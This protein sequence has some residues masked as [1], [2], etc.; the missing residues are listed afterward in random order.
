[1]AEITSD[2][3]TEAAPYLCQ[4]VE[5]ILWSFEMHKRLFETNRQNDPLKSP[6]FGQFF[7]RLNELLIDHWFLCVA[8]L[9]DRAYTSQW[10]L[11]LE[12][13]AELPHLDANTAKKMKEL[14]QRMEGF[15]DLIK[16]PRNK[17]LA[18]NDVDQITS[19]ADAGSFQPGQDEEYIEQLKQFAS[20]VS[21]ELLNKPFVY[22]NLGPNDVDALV[23]VIGFGLN[24]IERGTPDPPP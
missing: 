4:K 20:L 7:V 18:H 8:R 23:S 15:A 21:S 3:L 9:H 12:Y 16:T 5:E 19:R 6:R 10:N 22:D 1:M 14:I 2:R 13:F 24:W 17:L 11:T